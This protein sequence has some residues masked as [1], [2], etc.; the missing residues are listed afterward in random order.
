MLGIAEKV[1][2]VAAHLHSR[3]ILHGDLYGHNIL[4]DGRGGALLGDFGAASFYAPGSPSGAALERLE[5]RAFGCL[6]EELVAHGNM[7]AALR[8]A[9]SALMHDCLAEVPAGR[10]DFVSVH[11]R[12]RRMVRSAGMHVAVAAEAESELNS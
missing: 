8:E 3:G 10:P 7:P 1:A 5:V 12:L 2:S 11:A 6:L 9:L 4:H